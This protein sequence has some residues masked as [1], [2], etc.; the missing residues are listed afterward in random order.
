MK[1]R[2]SLTLTLALVTTI[3]VVSAFTWGGPSQQASASMME[4]EAP[5]QTVN[6]FVTHGHCN[7]PF[8]G[9]VSDLKIMEAVRTDMGN[10]L[11]N[12]QV[13]F[14]IDPGSFKACGGDEFTAM[15]QTPGLF[16]EGNEVFTF[17]STSVYTL[18]LDWCQ[19]NGKMSIKGVDREVKFFVTGIRKPGD[20]RPSA[21]VLEGQLNLYD[22]GID[23]DRIV[24]GDSG[25]SAESPTQ[26]MHLNMKIEMC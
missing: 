21:L 18:G 25:R 23:Y 26:W 6:L 5:R 7:T 19:L 3:A 11:E 14:V 20:S 1:S 16:R 9:I 4:E 10:P 22:W 17:H 13:S 12:M 2:R 15:V 8:G 24:H